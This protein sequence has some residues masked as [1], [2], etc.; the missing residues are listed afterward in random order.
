MATLRN[1][2]GHWLRD[3]AAAQFDLLEADHGVISVNSAGRTVEEQNELI[4][5]YYVIGGRWNRPPYLYA[6]ARPALASNHVANGGIAV[7]TSHISHMLKYGEAYGF[8]QPHDWD[9]PHFEFDPAR[10]R[11]R[12]S[13]PQ[14]P[15]KNDE[16]DDM[17]ITIL[18]RRNSQLTKS[19]YDPKAGRAIR[20]ISKDENT[21]F[22]KARS[23]AVVY[24]TVSDAEYKQRGGAA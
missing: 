9:K 8:Y 23:G 11:I 13:K 2:P 5:R 22:R 10:V 6:P 14:P 1:H 12:P 18:E 15:I 17:P 21:A 3:D 24:V 19:L 7:D 4:H 20:A 16:D